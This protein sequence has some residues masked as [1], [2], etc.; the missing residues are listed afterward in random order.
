MSVSGF[1]SH[2]VSGQRLA[3]VAVPVLLSQTVTTQVATSGMAGR[4]HRA[5]EVPGQD[6]EQQLSQVFVLLEHVSAN[7]IHQQNLGSEN[8]QRS[9]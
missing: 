1:P 7:I 8:T 2:E 4:E 9:V 3:G 5:A 6:V